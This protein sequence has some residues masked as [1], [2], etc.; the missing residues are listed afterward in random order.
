MHLT[1]NTILITGGTSGIGRAL[2]RGFHQ[3]DNQVIIAERRQ[4]L[5][6]EAFIHSWLQSL[7]FQ[8]RKTSV[9]V[10]E[11]TYF[12]PKTE[13]SQRMIDLAPEAVD[14]LRVFTKGNN[15]EF[16]LT[17]AEPQSYRDVRLLPVRLHLVWH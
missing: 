9:E 3:R 13:E 2:A 1:G 17:G 7:C 10:L 4:H 8:L 6:D 14:A 12:E 15:S 11:L 16:V 5:L